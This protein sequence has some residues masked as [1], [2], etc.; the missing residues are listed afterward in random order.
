MVCGLAILILFSL[1]GTGYTSYNSSA[2]S[3]ASYFTAALGCFLP[4]ANNCFLSECRL[5]APITYMTNMTDF[6]WG[7]DKQLLSTEGSTLHNYR[8]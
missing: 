1:V 4:K 5:S 3:K 6:Y 2:I 7:R 8:I